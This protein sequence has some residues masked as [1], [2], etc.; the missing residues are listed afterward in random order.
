ME[1]GQCVFVTVH[2]SFLLQIPDAAAKARA[3]DEFVR[4][5]VAIRALMATD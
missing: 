1:D 4:D 5:L 2:P 3:Y